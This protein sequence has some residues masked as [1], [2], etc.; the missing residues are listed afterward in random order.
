MR[1]TIVFEE[2]TSGGQ[3]VSRF[4]GTRNFISVSK[5]PIKVTQV[6]VFIAHF[7]KT[8]YTGI[9]IYEYISITGNP[10]LRFVYHKLINMS[11]SSVCADDL[12]IMHFVFKHFSSM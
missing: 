3:E 1:R 9:A 11:C 8:P 6:D 2:L 12:Q 10:S 5:V 7:C 4:Y